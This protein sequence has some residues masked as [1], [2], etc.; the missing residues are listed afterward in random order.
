MGDR[1]IDALARARAVLVRF[2]PEPVAKG[3]WGSPA[4]KTHL[5]QRIVAEIPEHRVYVEPFAGGGQVLFT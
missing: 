5:A 2:A 1:V 4:G 3:I